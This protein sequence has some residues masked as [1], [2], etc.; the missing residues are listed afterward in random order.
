MPCPLTAE[1]TD[2]ALRAA[3]AVGGGVLGVDLIEGPDRLYVLEVNHTVEFHGL[4]T[5]HGD[6]VDVA[7]AIVA[8][9]LDPS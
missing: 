2:L 6:E 3:K 4:Q 5:A 8:H 9:L 1:L 7:E